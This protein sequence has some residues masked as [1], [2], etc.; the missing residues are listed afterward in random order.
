MPDLLPP[1]GVHTIVPE[2]PAAIGVVDL[3]GVTFAASVVGDRARIGVGP[4]CSA[5]RIRVLDGLSRSRW[6]R[7]ETLARHLGSTPPALTRSTLNP[8]AELGLIE[9]NRGR[10]RSTGVWSPIALRLTAVELKL[11][12][13]RGALR[14]ADNFALSTD[15]AWVILDG[16]H[17][18]AAARNLDRFKEVGVGLGAVDPSGGFTVLSR[19]R[20]RQPVRWLRSLMAERAWAAAGQLHMTAHTRARQVSKKPASM[21]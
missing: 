12:K 2:I 14:Q 7:V 10:I 21:R 6:R 19:P 13:W 5:T 18:G 17:V 8:L 4:I 15:S 3:L 20:R 9:M 16:K 1:P 11:A